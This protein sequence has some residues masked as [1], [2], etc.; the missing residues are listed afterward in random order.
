MNLDRTGCETE[1]LPWLAQ[2]DGWISL[3]FHSDAQ[4]HGA[5]K[6]T[7]NAAG[8]ALKCGN[9][10]LKQVQSITKLLSGDKSSLLQD[11][12]TTEDE[13]ICRVARCRP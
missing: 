5:E 1:D 9:S 7:H 11:L 10:N 6:L 13:G 3:K 4:M 8:S 12:P 2:N